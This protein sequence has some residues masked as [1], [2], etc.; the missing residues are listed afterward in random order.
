MFERFRRRAPETKASAAAPALAVLHHTGRPRW[1]PRDYGALAR[2]GFTR[3]PV[4]YRAVRMIAEAAASV[5]FVL[6]EGRAELDTH[7]MLDLLARPNPAQTGTALLE[8]AYAGLQVAGNTYL[9]AVRL[10]GAVRELYALRADRM[11]V[12]PSRDG[13]PAAYIYS[14]GGSEARLAREDVLHLKLFHPLD[15]HYGFPFASRR[16]ARALAQ[17]RRGARRCGS[18]RHALHKQGNNHD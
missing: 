10:N 4:V 3:N 11:R 1:T 7:P 8:H 16:L 6:Y 5:P 17:E 2:Q 14:A 12:V 9:E 13:W 18:D 15:D